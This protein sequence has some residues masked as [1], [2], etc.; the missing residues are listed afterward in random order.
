M[1][2]NFNNLRAEKTFFEMTTN[3][4]DKKIIN[5]SNCIILN[6]ITFLNDKNYHKQE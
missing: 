5:Y 1:E 6:I 2:D 4:K 3:T